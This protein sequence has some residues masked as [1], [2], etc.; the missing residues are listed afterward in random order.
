MREKNLGFT[1][2][3]LLVVITIIGLLTGLVTFNFQQARRRARD[4][5]RK[6]ELK[7]VMNALELYKNDQSSQ[8]Y[9]AALDSLVSGDYLKVLP[10][11]PLEKSLDGSWE[12]YQYSRITSLTYTLTTCLENRGDPEGGANCNEDSRGKLYTLTQP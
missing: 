11:D 8:A 6:S 4:V 10:I 3:E 7:Q 12:D 5:Q 9:P 2:I 1:L